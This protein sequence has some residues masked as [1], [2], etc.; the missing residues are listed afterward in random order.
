MKGEESTRKEL[1]RDVLHF[2]EKAT[3]TLLALFLKLRPH[4]DIT[5]VTVEKKMKAIVCLLWVL[6]LI[7]HLQK[8]SNCYVS[9]FR[10]SITLT[11][12]VTDL[13]AS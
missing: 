3:V 7:Q 1:K 8:L 10:E 5:T 13:K 2:S 9:L 4:L 11:S 12:N 6:C